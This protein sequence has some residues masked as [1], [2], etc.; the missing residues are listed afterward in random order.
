ML[1]DEGGEVMASTFHAFCARILRRE[2]EHLGYSSHFTI[3]DTDDSRR[4]MKEC[5]KLANVEEKV[6]SH[7]A[8]LGEIGRAK[9]CR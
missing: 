3:Y 9:D 2:C 8:I 5:M 1:G 4:L 7:K 6:L